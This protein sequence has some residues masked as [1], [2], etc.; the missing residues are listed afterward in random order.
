MRCRKC[1]T[2]MDLIARSQDGNRDIRR[3]VCPKASCQESSIEVRHNAFA[4]A[5]AAAEKPP[6]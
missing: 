6:R 2:R 3:Y 4:K 5:A 1:G